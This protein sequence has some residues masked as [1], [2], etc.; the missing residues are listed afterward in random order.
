[1]AKVKKATI[2]FDPSKA[3]HVTGYALYVEPSVSGQVS[4]DSPR[5]DLGMPQEINGKIE[6]DLSTIAALAG[7][8]GTYNIGI[9]A[10][11]AT[12]NESDIEVIENIPLSFAAPAPPA[13][14]TVSRG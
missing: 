1:M 14:L 7:K 6:V 4:Y 3:A 8:S 13:G 2:G 12:G 11:D 9:S 10:Y 5:T